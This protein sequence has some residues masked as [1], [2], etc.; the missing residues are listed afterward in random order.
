MDHEEY[1]V[2]L[3][4]ATCSGEGMSARYT[5]GLRHT[6]I[7]VVRADDA[8]DTTDVFRK[9]C[10]LTGWTHATVDRVRAYAPETGSAA[11]YLLAAIENARTTGYGWIVYGERKH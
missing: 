11:T 3:G 9:N 6:I 4:K 1:Q 10:D 5:M 2:V 7:A 8:Q